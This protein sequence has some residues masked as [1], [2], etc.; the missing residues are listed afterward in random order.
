MQ[1][2]DDSLVLQARAGNRRAFEA[3]VVRVGRL[4]YSHVF[5]KVRDSHRAEDL[6]QETLLRAWS[7]IASLEDVSRFRP[8]VLAIADR[9]ILDAVKSDTRMKRDGA[10]T[11][12]LLESASPGLP[13]EAAAELDEQRERV[14]KALQEI[15]EAHRQVLMLRYLAG[16]DY[17]TIS[18]Q[19][20]L[21]NGSLRGLLQR[22]MEMLRE[23]LR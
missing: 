7:S 18:K 9:V 21:S 6:V 19:L 10:R 8:W 15:P 13:P 20:A 11:E 3:L 14:L 17:E 1:S 12:A 22:G 5:L 16:A 23:K 4:I 2:A